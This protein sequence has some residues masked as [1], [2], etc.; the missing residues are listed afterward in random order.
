MY[1]RKDKNNRSCSVSVTLE[2]LYGRGNSLEKNVYLIKTTAK[3]L[4][5]EG[6]L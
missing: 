3:Q 2:S 1:R 6:E 4:M 5:L